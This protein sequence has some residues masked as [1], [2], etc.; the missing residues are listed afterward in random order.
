[1]AQCVG[2]WRSAAAWRH[3]SSAMYGTA[4]SASSW[5]VSRLSR[6]GCPWRY[7][8]RKRTTPS[9][10]I[11]TQLSIQ[12]QGPTAQTGVPGQGSRPRDAALPNAFTVEL[13]QG[14]SAVV[15]HDKAR[16]CMRS[17]RSPGGPYRRW[18][19]AR[20]FSH[21]DFPEAPNPPPTTHPLM[22][23]AG[24]VGTQAHTSTIHPMLNTNKTSDMGRCRARRRPR[25]APFGR[26]LD[27]DDGAADP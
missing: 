14:S 3:V 12:Q 24:A 7:H 2:R 21:T 19:M 9:P 25:Q 22:A 16:C 15:A 23:A 27:K 8:G 10:L 17:P 5:S 18:P 6:Q 4:Q 1:V 13:R 11:N 20:G 26:R